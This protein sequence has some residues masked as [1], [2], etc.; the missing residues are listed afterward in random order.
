[1]RT[2]PATTCRPVRAMA[3]P[4]PAAAL[5]S[6]VPVSVKT[7]PID[8]NADPTSS[9]SPTRVK[10]ERSAARLVA[11]PRVRSTTAARSAR[12]RTAPSRLAWVWPCRFSA[13]VAARRMALARASAAVGGVM[14]ARAAADVLNDP[15][16][17]RPR[18][19]R[20]AAAVRR[21]SV[22]SC[23]RARRVIRAADLRVAARIARAALTWALRSRRARVTARRRCTAESPCSRIG[24]A[25]R[26]AAVT[27]ASPDA[28]ALRRA[29][30]RA[31]G[32]ALPPKVA[33]AARPFVD[34]RAFSC[35]SSPSALIRAAP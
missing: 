14:T 25:A 24:S 34:A 32:V 29:A 9:R 1:M 31:S 2:A 19:P 6:V 21:A 3:L 30:A 18:T 4:T 10:L 17:K 26:T 16:A 7:R 12:A 8:R 13:A 5:R 28:G 27:S 15:R 35:P 23:P 20:S 11:P 22:A 33:Q